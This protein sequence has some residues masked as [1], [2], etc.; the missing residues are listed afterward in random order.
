M[1][2]HDF[3]DLLLLK[4]A[5]RAASRSQPHFS[6]HTHTM[7][8]S[9][10][11]D[12]PLHSRTRTRAFSE[13]GPRWSSLLLQTRTMSEFLTCMHAFLSYMIVCRWSC[14][15]HRHNVSVLTRDLESIEGLQKRTSAQTKANPKRQAPA[16][17][18]SLAKVILIHGGPRTDGALSTC[19]HACREEVASSRAT[20]SWHQ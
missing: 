11:F 16:I 7:L 8:T 13:H 6:T 17:G 3:N 5:V 18:V 1:L 20:A 10:L 4:A 12:W 9:R 14:V 2:S 19:P 15:P